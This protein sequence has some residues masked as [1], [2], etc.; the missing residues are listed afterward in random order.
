[1]LTVETIELLCQIISEW[2]PHWGFSL[3]ATAFWLLISLPSWGS[4]PA[5]LMKGVGSPW[6]RTPVMEFETIHFS[7]DCFVG[8]FHQLKD[9]WHQLWNRNFNL[10]FRMT[11]CCCVGVGALPSGRRRQAF[12]LGFNTENFFTRGRQL[13]T[14]CLRTILSSKVC[15]EGR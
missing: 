11:A 2:K 4:W 10:Y 3:H 5:C 9:A 14:A 8:N 1:M 15:S 7:A 13:L 12:C 6:P